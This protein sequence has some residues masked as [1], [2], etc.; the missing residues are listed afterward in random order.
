LPPTDFER[1]IQKI[2]EVKAN[3][4]KSKKEIQL[5]QQIQKQLSKNEL[6][7]LKKLEQKQYNSTLDET[8]N[9][10][11]AAFV[12]K[13]EQLH[14]QRIVAIGMLAQLRGTSVEKISKEFGF[15]SIT[16]G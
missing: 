16:N 9:Q 5:I 1:F 3:A 11:M 13:I 2:Q 15:Q 10:E 8:E 7:R 6:E 12:H 14:T 4:E